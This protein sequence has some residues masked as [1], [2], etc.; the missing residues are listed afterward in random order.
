MEAERPTMTRIKMELVDVF[1]S[2]GGKCLLEAFFSFI[3][4]MI[5]DCM[6]RFSLPWAIYTQNFHPIC[7]AF[8]FQTECSLDGGND[9][10][11]TQLI[12][13]CLPSEKIQ[14]GRSWPS[15]VRVGHWWRWDFD[16]YLRWGYGGPP[17]V[18]RAT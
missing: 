14:L 7:A 9:V 16:G 18:P 12:F 1:I 3:W 15:A 10:E 6:T 13:Q 11:L 5:D 8:S 2:F 4:W 17:Y